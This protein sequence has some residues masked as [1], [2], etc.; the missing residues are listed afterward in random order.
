MDKKIITVSFLLALPI[1]ALAFNSGTIPNAAPGLLINDLIDIVFYILWPIVVAF[2]VISFIASAVLFMTAQ[3]DPLRL[4]QARQALLFG[5]IGV[6][7]S[8]LAF[9]VPFIIRNSIGN[10]I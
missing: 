2:S 1:V 10:G 6:V 9:S 3:D 7:V 4:I 5:V 8:L